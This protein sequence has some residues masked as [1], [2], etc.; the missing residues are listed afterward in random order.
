MKLFHV[1]RQ[2]ECGYDEY[3]SFVCAAED[4]EAARLTH[5]SGG[6][7]I[8]IDGV[9]RDGHW[10]D[11]DWPAPGTLK[12]SEIGIAHKDERGVYCASFNAG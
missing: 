3:D 1:A 6:R 11:G 8:W 2:D 4:E 9:W 5:P 7:H 10:T 12:V